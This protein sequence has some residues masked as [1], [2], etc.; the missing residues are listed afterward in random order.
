MSTTDEAIIS[1]TPK[2][3]DRPCPVWC[4][5]P[6]GHPWESV[7]HDGRVSR[8]HEKPVSPHDDEFATVTLAVAETAPTVADVAC[9]Y[10]PAASGPSTFGEVAI[11]AEIVD[12]LERLTPQQASQLAAWLRQASIAANRYRTATFATVVTR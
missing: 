2:P 9:D 5:S 11:N 7:T 6:D 10:V 4:S 1:Q 8:F 3:V 12:P